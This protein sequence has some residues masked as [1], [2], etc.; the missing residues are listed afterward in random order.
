M[1]FLGLDGGRSYLKGMLNFNQSRAAAA[2]KKTFKFHSPEGGP[3]L[4]QRNSQLCSGDG[5]NY[6]KGILNLS[7]LSGRTYSKEILDFIQQ[8]GHSYSKGIL[9]LG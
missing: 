9:D 6:L 5:R 2:K 7:Q 4:F 8:S 3:H 1:L